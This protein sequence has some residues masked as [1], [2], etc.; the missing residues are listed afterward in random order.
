[1]AEISSGVYI[2]RARKQS[3]SKVYGRQVTYEFLG[4]SAVLDLDLGLTALVDNL[5]GEV[6]HIGLDLGVLEAAT[7]ETLRVE[8]SVVRVHRD[9]VLGRIADKTLGVREGH[10]RRR[11]AVTLCKQARQ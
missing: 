3:K 6:L 1:M 4:L 2:G 9:L 5:E 7:N 11:C 10:V 8:H